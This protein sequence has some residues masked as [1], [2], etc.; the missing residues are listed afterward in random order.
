MIFVP[1]V[2]FFNTLFDPYVVKLIRNSIKLMS[3]NK[4]TLASIKTDHSIGFFINQSLLNGVAINI[5]AY[6]LYRSQVILIIS[7]TTELA[8]CSD[9][10]GR[11]S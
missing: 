2:G 7:V 6:L 3:K 4:L 1:S 11:Y 8:A 5:F 10:T 9:L